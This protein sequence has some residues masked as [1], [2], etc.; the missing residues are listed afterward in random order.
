MATC[1]NSNTSTTQI[2]AL[3]ASEYRIGGMFEVNISSHLETKA[4]KGSAKSKLTTPLSS[5][6]GM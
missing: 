6:L 4:D 1:D 5:G 2:A 3:N